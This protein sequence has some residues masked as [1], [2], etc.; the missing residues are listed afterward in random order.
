MLNTFLERG[1]PAKSGSLYAI[2]LSGAAQLVFLK[3]PP[4]AAIDLAVRLAQWDPRAKRYDKL[5]NAV[6]RRVSEKGE[7]IADEPRCSP[8]QHAGLAVGALGRVLGRGAGAKKSP[9]RSSS[10]RRST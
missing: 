5:V 8:R 10:S 3:T 2:L 4:H 6:L 1:L 7:A 9:R